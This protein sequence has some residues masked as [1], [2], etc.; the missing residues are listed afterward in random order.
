MLL[1]NESFST[2]YAI[3][4]TLICCDLCLIW[5][6]VFPRANSRK[7]MSKPISIVKIYDF[8]LFDKS[9]IFRTL[10]INEDGFITKHVS[11]AGLLY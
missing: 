6:T 3:G 5:E 1:D 9:H 4:K 10:K 7:G 11:Y 2:L 8:N